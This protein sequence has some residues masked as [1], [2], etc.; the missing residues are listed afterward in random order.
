MSAH[1]ECA[2]QE[3]ESAGGRRGMTRVEDDSALKSLALDWLEWCERSL[4]SESLK[5]FSDLRLR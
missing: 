3:E 2:I 1:E 5:F 4:A